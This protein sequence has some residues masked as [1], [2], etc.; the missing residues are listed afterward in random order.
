MNKH[1]DHQ[2]CWII[3]SDQWSKLESWA[4]ID[5]L[6]KHVI[7]IVIERQEEVVPNPRIRHHVLEFNN[8]ISST[9]IRDT[10][11]RGE[12]SEDLMPEVFEYANTKRIYTRATDR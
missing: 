4:K 8:P 2:I 11:G 7:F 1:P 6:R 3:G 12:Y 10:M 5:Y 9:E